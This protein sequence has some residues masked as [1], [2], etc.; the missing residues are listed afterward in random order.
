MKKSQRNIDKTKIAKAEAQ[1]AEQSKRIDFYITEYSV[2]LLAQKMHNGEFVVP[3]YQRKFTWEA[4]RRS[5]FLESL[6][7]G[8]P[9]PFL[10]F[11]EM[12][13]GLLEIVD[14]SQRLRTIESFLY[15]DFCLSELKCLN[16]LSGF[17][18][19]DLPESRQR[20]IKNR[21]V[22]GIVLN[23]HADQEAR[24]DMFDRINT[25]SKIAN[26]TEVRR[27]ALAGPFIDL[28]INLSN[29]EILEKL[30][31][32][33]EK[34][35][36][37]R[38]YEELIE[39]LFSYGDG[40]EKYRDNPAEFIS[41]YVDKMNKSFLGDPLLH[42]KYK[43]RFYEVMNFVKKHFPYGF[44]KTP[45]S[46]STYR[47]RFEAIAVGVDRAIRKH[48]EL[49]ELRQGEI[50]VDSW[51]GSDEFLKITSAD[52]ANTRSRLINRI[53]YVENKLVENVG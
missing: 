41:E 43:Q 18:F 4:E 35:K 11:W 42:D 17:S 52:G 29:E 53:S 3:E 21:S 37:L 51:I 20:K 44:R 7:M 28:V 19:R 45:T 1:I 10:F 32:I 5:R 31:P 38:E 2:E 48:P 39:R 47:S 9:I 34:K 16:E 6:I 24:L 25:G 33:S 8:L 40:I 12:P 30:A 49:K 36:S 26:S 23:E 46:N 22:R 14:G 27:G 13:D 15:G 50:D